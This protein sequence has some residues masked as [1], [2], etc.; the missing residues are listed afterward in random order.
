LKMPQNIQMKN[1]KSLLEITYFNNYKINLVLCTY[2][3]KMRSN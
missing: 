1:L 3:D 2:S